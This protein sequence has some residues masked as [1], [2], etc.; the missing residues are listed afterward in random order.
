MQTRTT[1]RGATAAFALCAALAGGTA[2]ASAE[3]LKLEPAA[4]ETTVS[5][6]EQMTSTGSSTISASVN[7]KVA[8]VFQNTLSGHKLDC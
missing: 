1:L 6:S 3:P 8:C 2:A 7:A 4:P 5:V